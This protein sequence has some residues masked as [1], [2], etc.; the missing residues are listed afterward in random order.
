MAKN[1][2]VAGLTA[3][4]LVW[5]AAWMV[6]FFQPVNIETKLFQPCKSTITRWPSTNAKIA[7][8]TRK[9]HKRAQ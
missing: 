4:T 8:I 3:I 9:C 1:Y 7:H 5:A 2:K 6:V